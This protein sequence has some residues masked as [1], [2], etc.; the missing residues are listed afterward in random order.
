METTQKEYW[1]FMVLMLILSWHGDATLPKTADSVVKLETNTTLTCTCPWSGNLSQIS[2]EKRTDSQKEKVAVYHT[3]YGLHEFGKYKGRVKFLKSLPLDGSILITQTTEED[4]GLYQCSV[5]SF[6]KGSWTKDIRVEKTA[7]DIDGSENRSEVVVEKG[8]N[9]TLRC[10]YVQNGTVHQV[11]FEKLGEK[12]KDTI[13]LC[14][15][16]DGNFTGSDYKQRILL[17]CSSIQASL[18]IMNIT[19][20]DGGIYRCRLRTNSG[21]QTT[22]LSLSLL[23]W[24]GL[25]N[26]NLIFYAGAGAAGFIVLVILVATTLVYQNRRKKKRMKTRDKFQVVKKRQLNNYEQASVYDRMKKKA[27]HQDTDEIYV[28]IPNPPRRTKK[29]T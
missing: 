16:S 19:D 6:P 3:T 8:H 11:T 5:H 22:T 27:K 14:N 9:F 21:N 28:N 13:A 25:P 23:K 15:F 20:K 18:L 29:K 2:W 26:M 24:A 1:Y 10:H 17:N 7:V 12:S 4:L